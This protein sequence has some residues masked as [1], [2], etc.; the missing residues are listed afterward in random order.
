MRSC[1]TW[2]GDAGGR[3]AT[4]LLDS[5]AGPVFL[6]KTECR[7]AEHHGQDDRRIRPF[8]RDDGN[9]GCDDKNQNQRTLELIQ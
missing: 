6:H 1:P 4:Q 2:A 5:V 7:T 9:D 3:I 8:P